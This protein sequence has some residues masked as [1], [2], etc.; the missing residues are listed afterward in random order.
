VARAIALLALLLIAALTVQAS[1]AHDKMTTLEDLVGTEY[2]LYT[3]RLLGADEMRELAA[4]VADAYG[5]E[6]PSLRRV[7]ADMH[8]TFHIYGARAK[9]AK[10]T[11][12]IIVGGLG[13]VLIAQG[14][15]DI[16]RQKCLPAEG[17]ARILGGGDWEAREDGNTTI[18]V[19]LADY[20]RV[21]DYGV[22]GSTGDRV[23]KVVHA[24]Q[25]DAR[26]VELFLGGVPF[27]P[28]WLQACG[29]SLIVAGAVPP[30]AEPKKYVLSRD[31][32]V[33]LAVELGAQE[34][35]EVVVKRVWLAIDR[36]LLSIV[37][38]LE[39]QAHDETRYAVADPLTLR[40]YTVEKPPVP[41][42]P[43][44]GWGNWLTVTSKSMEPPEEPEPLVGTTSAISITLAV[45]L[46]LAG[47]F[48]AWH[49]WGSLAGY[50]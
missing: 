12:T 21:F 24:Y 28:A 29:E 9:G 16:L 18:K 3:L 30:L 32:A 7:Y 39:L 43:G 35:G 15:R 47:I 36:R 42:E 41:W 46:L 1:I 26:V 17:V 8:G 19:R 11:A 48:Y 13:E 40:L 22:Y 6:T 5:L 4:R 20:V 25:G 50:S 2:T 31:D 45:T 33:G 49:R 27:R 23:R 38:V 10:L 44:A 14:Q 34:P 37:L